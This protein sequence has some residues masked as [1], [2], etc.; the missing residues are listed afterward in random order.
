MNNSWTYNETDKKVVAQLSE[1]LPDRIFDIHAHIYRNS[2]LN[3]LEASGEKNGHAE[4]SVD[5]WKTHV[6]DFLN[7][8]TPEGG[9]FFPFPTPKLDIEGANNY[10]LSQIKEEKLSRGLVV[11]SPDMGREKLSHLLKQ[12]GIVGM[13]PYHVFSKETPTWES[14]LAGFLPD[15]Q[16]ELADAYGS[17]VMLHIVKSGSIADADNIKEIREMCTRYPGMK[18]ILAHSARSFHAPHAAEG[19]KKLR[20]IENIW[21]DNS[22]IC[23]PESLMV[24]LKEFG[25]RKLMWGSDFPVSQLRGKSVTVGDGFVWLD[26]NFCDWKKVPFAHPVLVGIESLRALKLAAGEFGLNKAD[27]RDIF[28]ENAHRLLFEDKHPKNVTQELYHR[29]KKRIPGGTQ[30]LSKKPELMA[31]GRWPAYY[32]EARGC[33]VWDLDGRH[34]YDMVT[35]GIGS[36]LLG[37]SDPDVNAAVRR[38]INLGSM[39]S[40]NSPDEVELADLLCDIHPW[41]EQAR[42]TRAGGEA[43]AVAVRI[44]RATTNRSLVAICGYHGWHDWYLAAN[45]GENDALKGHLLP[46]LNPSGVPDQLRG[47]AVT[48]VNNDRQSFQKVIDEY[49]PRLAAVIM[50]PCR[51]VDPEPGFLEFVRDEAHRS[52]ALLIFDEIT[53]GWRLYFGGAHLHFGVSPDLAVLA[54]ALGNGFPIGAVIGTQEAMSGGSSSFISSTYWTE[55]IGPAAALATVQKMGTTNVVQHI[56]GVGE[57][58]KF[59]WARLGKKYGLPVET[60]GYPC[61][62]HFSFQHEDSEKLR[63]VY[64]QMMLKRGFLAGLS[65]YPTM[66][67]TDEVLSLYIQAIEDVFSHIGKALKNGS[68]NNLLDGEVAHS[69]FARLTK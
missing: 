32:R 8:V 60:S 46:G 30:L 59:E 16:L 37:F 27:I 26:E 41:A 10:L 63:T 9:L 65:I 64:T 47:T 69:G 57:K 58:I 61:L 25:P 42:F 48:F 35:N 18:L 22:A 43:C 12:P 19:I 49:G 14:S 54:K 51:S 67:H 45:L 7:G 28:F 4:F 36:C 39:S 68:V 44:A 62:A 34:Y 5:V 33:E 1:F 29:A 6:T 13:K 21:F 2:D 15:W 40:L 23:E 31:P 3:S 55:G 66:A 20:G 56:A 50:E 52:G 11:V 53:I 17:I 24:I 38:R